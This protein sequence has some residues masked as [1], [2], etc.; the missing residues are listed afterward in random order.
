MITLVVGTNRPNS[1]TAKIARSIVDIY[2]E[3]GAPLEV[4]DLA[5]LPADLFLPTSYAEK[6]ASFQPFVDRILASDGL[7]IVTPEYN[8]GVPGVLKYFIDMLPFP[9]SFESRAV[10]FVGVAAGQWGALRPVEQLQ[11]IFGYRNALIHPVRVFIAGVHDVLDEE[12]RLVDAGL[13]RRLAGQARSF[14]AF[15]DAVKSLRSR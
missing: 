3:H 2:A 12:G 13:K 14:T 7:V 6:P 9:E 11:A 15:V 8:G 4:L 1:N 10:S 5:D